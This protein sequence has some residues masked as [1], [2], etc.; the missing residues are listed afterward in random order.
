MK[1]KKSDTDISRFV[2]LI[3]HRD[4]CNYLAKYREKLF[5]SGFF[6][7]HSFPPAA[8]LA[9][10]SRPLSREE[11]RELAG[12]IRSFTGENGGKIRSGADTGIR[13]AG[14]LSFF[15]PI[16]NLS[17]GEEIFPPAAREKI[18]TSFLPP[19]LCAALLRPGDSAEITCEEAP[20]LSFRAASLANLAFRRLTAGDTNYSFEWKMSPPVWLPAYKRA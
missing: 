3:P 20:L 1:T 10:V 16:L 4:A 5:S 18:L 6:G 19:L 14:S 12:A 7:A 2:I 9:R 15:G 8:P 13:E 11:L 17:A